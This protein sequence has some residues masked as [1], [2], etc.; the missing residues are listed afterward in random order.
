VLINFHPHPHPDAHLVAADLALR[1]IGHALCTIFGR[2]A[3]D[4]CVLV[5]SSL[6]LC[7]L[8]ASG[9]RLLAVNPAS[10]VSVLACCFGVGR[11]GFAAAREVVDERVGV[12]TSALGCFLLVL[13]VALF[14]NIVDGEIELRTLP[15]C[16]APLSFSAARSPEAIL[17][18]YWID[19]LTCDD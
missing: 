8:V 15:W 18:V 7:I 11:V 9:Q 4:L 13:L 5:E 19:W 14:S 16:M 1:R 6:A 12:L 17:V 2:A 3:K 10:G